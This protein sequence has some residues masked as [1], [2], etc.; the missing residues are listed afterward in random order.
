VT[1][2]QNQFETRDAWRRFL[3][4]IGA[5]PHASLMDTLTKQGRMADFRT[6]LA[7]MITTIQEHLG[8]E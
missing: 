7:S 4:R 1:Y 2:Q 6:E 3:R 5:E 8:P